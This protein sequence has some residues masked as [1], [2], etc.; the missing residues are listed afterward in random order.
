[1]EDAS[2]PSG[3]KLLIEDYPY[4]SDGLLMWDAIKTW[5]DEYVS[6]YYKDAKS[7]QDD[8]ELQAWW[9]EIKTKGHTDK[10]GEA[11][12]PDVN[13]PE[14]LKSVLTTIIWVVSGFHA[15]VNFG[16][17]AYGGYVP[18]RPC[19]TRRL[20]PE[21]GTQ[22]YHEFLQNPEKF[23]M[24]TIPNQL[25]AT[26]TM[27]VVDTLSSHS[28]DEEYLGERAQTN[29]TND[30]AAKEA[31]KRFSMQMDVIERM[32]AHRNHDP[33]LKNRSGA[34]V[35]PYEILCPS[36]GPGK[37]GRGVPNSVSI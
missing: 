23:F 29:W 33:S 26:T 30:V 9:E 4:A 17:Y 28:P 7:V 12:W 1:M 21:E 15:A 18:N 19:I 14:D 16:Q 2:Q 32:I 37:T 10:K 6:L 22:A 36:S 20:I 3:V 31:F 8:I 34:G 13:T 24:S 25:Q 5:V 27:A 35:L 11:W